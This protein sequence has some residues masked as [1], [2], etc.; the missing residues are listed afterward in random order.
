MQGAITIGELARLLGQPEH[1][2]RRAADAANP[3]LPRVGRYR[4]IQPEQIPSVIDV[5]RQRGHLPQEQGA[6]V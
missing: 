2:I 1:R 4:L 3:N 5:L 6:S